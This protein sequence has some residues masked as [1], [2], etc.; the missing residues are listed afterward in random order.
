MQ[1]IYN[2]MTHYQLLDV[3]ESKV[4]G[5]NYFFSLILLMAHPKN[6]TLPF[7]ILAIVPV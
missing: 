3:S 7:Q 5:F 6:A 4:L 1:K 2:N